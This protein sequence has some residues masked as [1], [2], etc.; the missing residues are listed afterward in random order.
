MDAATTACAHI[1]FTAGVGIIQ[2]GQN[3][4][5]SDV[6]QKYQ[7]GSFLKVPPGFL[8]REEGVVKHA[9]RVLWFPA[10]L[11]YKAPYPTITHICQFSK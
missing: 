9:T 7:P 4:E 11:R 5:I 2:M 6:E 8:T 1:R 10:K 3:T